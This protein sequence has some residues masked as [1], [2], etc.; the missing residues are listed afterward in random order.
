[1]KPLLLTTLVDRR[2]WDYVDL[3]TWCAK[4]SYPEY[5][6]KI[7]HREEIFPN[8][9]NL[10]YTTNALRMVMPQELFSEYRYIYI[11][12]IDIMILR[13]DPPLLDFHVKDMGHKCFSNSIRNAGN[14]YQ[15]G[16]EVWRGNE[17]L[18][19]LHFCSREWFERVEPQAIKWRKYLG[20]NEVWRGFDGRILYLICK[21]VGFPIPP[22]R[23]LIRR[24]HGIHLGTFRLWRDGLSHCNRIDAKPMTNEQAKQ[25]WAKRV[26]PEKCRTWRRYM[27][28]PQYQKIVS[29]IKDPTIRGYVRDLD[30]YARVH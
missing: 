9:P 24:H 12:D 8:H 25:A 13:E 30:S 1:M 10:G 18:S 17:C 4:K 3:F 5:D 16:G 11:T 7:F 20:E 14:T 29:E 21:E 28:D 2:Y 23:G 6:V 27:E 26:S 22:K 15:S 19:G